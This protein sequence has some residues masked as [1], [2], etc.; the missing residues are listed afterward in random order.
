M[1]LLDELLDLGDAALEDEIAVIGFAL[2]DLAGDG[3]EHQILHLSE[4]GRLAE[5]PGQLDIGHL[6]AI[7]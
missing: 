4:V 7:F 5:S 3:G 6:L 1:K 2:G